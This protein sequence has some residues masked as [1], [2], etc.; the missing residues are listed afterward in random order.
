MSYPTTLPIMRESTT[1]R[2]GGFSPVRASNGVLKVR[3]L[4]STEKMTFNL[5]H[6]LSDAQK[7]TLESAYTANRTSNVTLT[8][9]EDGANYTCRFAGAPQYEKQPGYWVARVRLEEV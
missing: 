3:R 2:E 4:Y 1:S 8:W 9:P 7:T 6:W 5:V